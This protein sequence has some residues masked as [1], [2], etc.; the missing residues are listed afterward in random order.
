[1]T[2]P[3]IH[4]S[5]CRH[6]SCTPDLVK[7]PNIHAVTIRTTLLIHYEQLPFLLLQP[8]TIAVNT[9]IYCNSTMIKPKT[10]SECSHGLVD[11]AEALNAK[12]RFQD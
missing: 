4:D 12:L 9:K 10:L 1:M 5:Y 8:I 11:E 2:T 6:V 7:T 3:I